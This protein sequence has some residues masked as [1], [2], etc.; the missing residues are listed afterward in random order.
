VPARS[1]LYAPGDDRSRVDDAFRHDADVVVLDLEDG[2]PVERRAEARAI[3]AETLATRRAWVR[4][5]P[6]WSDDLE[7]DLEA[8]RGAVGLRL[9]KVRSADDVRRLAAGVLVI[10]SIES[11]AGL[12][13]TEK[14]AEVPGV[15]TLSLGSKDLTADLGCVDSWPA[16][17]PAR[18]RLV[19]ACRRA[20]IGAP[21]DS[22]YYGGDSA[23]LRA[24]AEAASRLG[25]S[26]KSTLWPAQVPTINAA[27]SAG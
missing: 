19:S 9:P 16:L 1:Y 10:C 18:E 11:A 17:L 8:A 22:V 24:A 2:V 6:A 3:V 13:A 12:A 15:L 21:V 4:V 26:G 14:I 27:F 23:G 7:A 20:G 5:N 25:F